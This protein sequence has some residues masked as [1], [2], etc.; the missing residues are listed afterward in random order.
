MSSELLLPT[1]RATDADSNPYSGAKWLFYIKGTTTPQEVYSDPE[2]TTSLGAVVEADS[3]GKFPN[4][5]FD[6]TLQYR[7]ICENASGSTILHDIP[8]INSGLGVELGELGSRINWVPRIDIP[9]NGGDVNFVTSDTYGNTNDGASGGNW[10]YG[11]KL[12]G[13]IDAGPA[14]TDRGQSGT[15]FMVDARY[16]DADITGGSTF[17]MAIYGRMVMTGSGQGGRLGVHGVVDQKVASD[18]AN[19]NRN[20]VGT[21]GNCHT[22]SGDGGTDTGANAK[23]AYFGG[24]FVTFLHAGAVNVLDGVGVEIDTVFS[25]TASV[26]YASAVTLGNAQK[27]RGVDV[28]C[29]LRF[30]GYTDTFGPGIGWRHLI[31]NTDANSAD[32]TYSGSTLWGTSWITN[33]ATPRAVTHGIDWRGHTF[34][35]SVIQAQYL[36]IQDGLWKSSFPQGII[37]LTNTTRVF[38]IQPKTTGD[39]LGV[40]AGGVGDI[41]RLHANGRHVLPQGLVNAANDAA[42]AAAGIEVNGL[43]RNGSVVMIRVV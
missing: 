22:Y 43:Y 41:L 20:Y 10:Y 4:I 34:S 33:P 6:A 3:G 7:G 2:L 25:P 24:G 35:G 5:Y 9:M 37:E 1:A 42:A 40:N 38:Q 16:D 31:C 28:D 36:D 15:L 39:Y 13:T 14:P 30:S 27:V 11:R 21:S 18:A 17:G 8:L 29:G 32:P 23:G 26:R 19:T 12:T